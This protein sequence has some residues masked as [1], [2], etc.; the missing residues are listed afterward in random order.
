M[1][2]VNSHMEFLKPHVHLRK[3]KTNMK[4]KIFILSILVLAVLMVIAFV[5]EM[6]SSPLNKEYVKEIME[7]TQQKYNIP[8]ISICVIDEKQIKYS[9]CEGVKVFGADEKISENDYFHIGSCSKSVLACLAAKLVEKK[10]IEWDTKFLEIYPELKTSAQTAYIEITLEDLLSC[11]AGIQ[12]YTS[13]MEEY[14]DLSASQNKEIGFIKYLLSQS[15]SA[16]QDESGR[17]EFLYSN[18]SYTLAAAMLK[19]VSGLSYEDLLQKYIVRELECNVFIGWPYEKS[20]D[21]PWGHFQNAD[22]S[23]TPIGPDSVYSIN[24]LIAPAGNLSMTSESFMKFVQL[25]LQGMTG[26]NTFVDS[27]SINYIDTKYSEFALGVW[28]GTRAG[29]SYICLD[30]SAGTYFAR[31]IIIPDSGFGFTILMNCGSEEAVEYITMELM[32]AH[33]NWWWMF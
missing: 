4:R 19:K 17:F 30:G 13:G 18:A 6:H 12:P 28:N 31:G 1:V 7:K 8:A 5:L 33:Y 16:L 15:P 25:H 9:V 26:I 14:P 21:Q 24:P 22:H 23:L 32:K 11:R 27:Q 10:L 29:K 2:S 20:Q 3:Q